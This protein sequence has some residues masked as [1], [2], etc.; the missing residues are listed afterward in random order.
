MKDYSYTK[1][2]NRL[3][4]ELRDHDSVDRPQEP[5]FQVLILSEKNNISTSRLLAL[6]HNDK[7]NLKIVS[8][9]RR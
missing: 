4:S 5:S 6:S 7:K 3:A 8:L 1:F 9:L 2:E